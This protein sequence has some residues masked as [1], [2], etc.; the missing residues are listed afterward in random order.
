MLLVA[1][2]L[3]NGEIAARLVLSEATVK[4]HVGRILTKLSLRDRV[5]VVVLAYETG[6]VRAGGG[7]GLLTAAAGPA[8]GCGRRDCRRRD[9]SAQHR[10]QEVAAQPG[11]RGD[12]QLVQDVTAAPARGDRARPSSARDR[13]RE[14]SGAVMPYA[15][16]SSLVVYGARA[17]LRHSRIRI[18]WASASIRSFS[19]STG[20]GPGRSGRGDRVVDHRPPA[21]RV[22]HHA[23][24]ASRS[25]TGRT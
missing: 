10:L 5:Q 17:R 23:D 13:C 7:S 9:P 12:V 18:G 1:Q 25:S 8:G 22:Q 3:S 15:S 4:T 21:R 2:G 19:S 6:L 20:A 14:T 24:A 16:A 11:D